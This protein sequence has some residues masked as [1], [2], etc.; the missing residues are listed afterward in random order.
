MVIHGGIDGH[1]RPVVFLKC[2]DNNRASTV[3]KSFVQATEN[4]GWPS[5]LR[6]DKGGENVDVAFAMF[7]V[8]G[9]NRGSHIAGSSTHNQRIERLWRDVFRCV[10][11]LYYSLF[12]ML[13]DFGFLSPTDD[14][15]LFCL[16]FIFTPIIN[17][18]LKEYSEAHNH[19]P[20]RTEHNWSPYQLWCHSSIAAQNEDPIDLNDYGVDPQG[21]APNGFDVPFVEVPDTIVTLSNMQM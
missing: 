10:C 4:F 3:C 14:V 12:Y 1:T 17:R 5:R 2:S 8:K 7:L 9:L 11:A 6:S 20:L 18:A 19:H 15:D 16:H 13:E 21:Q